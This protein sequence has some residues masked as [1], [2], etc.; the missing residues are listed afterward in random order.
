MKVNALSIFALILK[1]AQWHTEYIPLMKLFVYFKFK[2]EQPQAKHW[3]GKEN[4][5]G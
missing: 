4:H 5:M 3:W 1:V 2:M